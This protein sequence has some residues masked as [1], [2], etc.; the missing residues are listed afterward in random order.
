MNM[1]LKPSW[2]SNHESRNRTFF[3]TAA[4][5]VFACGFFLLKDIRLI[6]DEYT[7]HSQ[8][9][10]IVTGKNLLPSTC[11]YLP[12]YHWSM[13]F[14]S[15]LIHD[16]HPYA[17]RFL[18]SVCSFLCLVVFFL[19]AKKIDRNSAIQKSLLFLFLPPLFP[20]F[21]LIYTDVYSMFYVFLALWAALNR[22]LRLSGILGIL[23]LIV[24]QNN[25][26]WL[27]L[28]A[29]IAYFENVDTQDRWKDVKKRIPQ[30]SFFGLALILTIVFVI[31]NKGFVLGDKTN[32]F[33][34][35]TA[36]NL[37]FSAYLFFFLFLPQNLAN[38][39]KI[40]HFL[41]QNKLILLILIELFFV[42][43]LFFKSEHLYNTLAGH[44]HNRIVWRME[45]HK[46]LSFL[47]IAYT[48]LSLCVTR[49]QQKSFYLFYPVAILF[50]ITLPVIEIRY[51]FIP[52]SLFLLFKEKSS[53]RITLL[54]LATYVVPIVCLMALILDRTYFP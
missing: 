46:I 49:L 40:L 36:G 3:F 14:L 22:R 38:G 50:L 26:L 48:V 20:F 29:F 37:F 32:H 18:S 47:P 52:F 44:I 25:I 16:H 13:A 33:L 28:I 41:K 45:S 43:L 9:L 5:I 54:T 17:L 21:F 53:E 51:T 12:G 35:L 42:Y 30:F 6:A 11:P 39:S 8:I 2:E 31:W 27:G 24:R 23:S 34:S 4:L 7:H 15:S 10:E 19:T 1:E